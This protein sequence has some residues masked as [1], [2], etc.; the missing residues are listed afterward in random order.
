LGLTFEGHSFM[1]I[2]RK[3]GILSHDLKLVQAIA[4][5]QKEV[6]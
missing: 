4:F 5:G 1:P 6:I 3:T 2:L